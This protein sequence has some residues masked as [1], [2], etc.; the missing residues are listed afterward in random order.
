MF[1]WIFL[2]SFSKKQH[3]VNMVKE[4]FCLT[5]IK[6]AKKIFKRKYC[7]A[8]SVLVLTGRSL[9]REY[10]EYLIGSDQRRVVKTEAK[11]QKNC[12]QLDIDFGC[13]NGK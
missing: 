1:G 2:S 6:E 10:I 5:K 9:F 7:F 8:K 11:T 13:F 12:K 4:V 3:V